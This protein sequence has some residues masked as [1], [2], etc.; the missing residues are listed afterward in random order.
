MVKVFIVI[1]GSLAS[2]AIADDEAKIRGTLSWTETQF[3]VVT[4]CKTGAEYTFGV[5]ASAP[6]FKLIQ[7]AEKLS[8]QGSVMVTVIGLV[9]VGDKSTIRNPQVLKVES[10]TCE[11]GTT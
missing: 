6:Y 10:G 3:A 9:E 11:N 2:S 1:L 7:E 8:S 5:M 4:E